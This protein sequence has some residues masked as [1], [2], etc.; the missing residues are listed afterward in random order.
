MKEMM[1]SVMSRL[2][3]LE[4]AHAGKGS[5]KKDMDY[6]EEGEMSDPTPKRPDS[7]M[8]KSKKSVGM[9]IAMLKARK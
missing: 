4:K 1:K 2:D 6:Q 5:G 9:V 3:A 7:D 8:K